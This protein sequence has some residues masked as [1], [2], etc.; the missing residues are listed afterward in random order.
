VFRDL[1]IA[2]GVALLGI[3][4]ILMVQTGS[5]TLAGIIMLAIPLTVIGIMPGF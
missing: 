2:F 4:V 3:F 5:A 1:G